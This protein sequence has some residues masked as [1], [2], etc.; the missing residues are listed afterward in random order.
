MV[1]K[2]DYCANLNNLKS[3]AGLLNFKFVKGDIGSVRDGSW[4]DARETL[5]RSIQRASDTPPPLPRC[6]SSHLRHGSIRSL[7][8]PDAMLH[9][10]P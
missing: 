4:T 1:D 10:M 7:D 2:L 5:A 9:P 3:V 8:E 6:S